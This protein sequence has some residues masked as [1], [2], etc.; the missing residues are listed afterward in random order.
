MRTLEKSQS[1]TTQNIRTEKIKTK[2]DLVHRINEATTVQQL[3]ELS[4]TGLN[5]QNAMTILSKL[6]VLTASS[7]ATVKEFEDDYRFLKICRLLSKEPSKSGTNK[8][9]T[10]LRD[11]VQ[12]STEL[13][14][15]LSVAGDEEAAKVVE[16]LSLPQKVRVL[17]SLARKKTRSVVV[18]RSL[19]HTISSHS[20]K[21]NLKECS[22]VLFAMNSLNFTNELLLSRIGIDINRELKGN[23][24]K[25]AVVGS[26]VTSLGF[27][28]FKEPTLLNNLTKWIIDKHE[29]CRPKDLA[30]LLLTLSLVN[31]QTEHVDSIKTVLIPKITKQELSY[32]DWLDFVWAL[33]LLNLHQP[34][35]LESVLWYVHFSVAFNSFFFLFVYFSSTK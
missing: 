14:M 7:Q 6:S 19:A 33:S 27:L 20:G 17:S 1:T 3:L 25:T 9:G 26:I 11:E 15:V 30:S 2:I 10:A 23:V 16:G 28:K 32:A 29:L 21:L 12:K 5:Q 13:E 22:D 8:T 24:D 4:E 31:Y 35:H 18:L 34:D